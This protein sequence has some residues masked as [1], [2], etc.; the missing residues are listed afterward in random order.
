VL[1]SFECGGASEA[2]GLGSGE[3]TPRELIGSVIG[4]VGVVDRMGAAN[5]LTYR[6]NSAGRQ[7]PESFEGGAAD[8]L[9]TLTGLAGSPEATTFSA[10]VALGGEEPLEVNASA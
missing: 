9:T 3:G 10:L 4:K 2:T 8:T 5:T 7:E 6:A 1:A